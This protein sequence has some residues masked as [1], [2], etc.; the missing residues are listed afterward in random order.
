MIVIGVNM[1]YF[2][3]SSINT[4]ISN[5]EIRDKE[6]QKKLFLLFCYMNK[7]GLPV[8]IVKQAKRAIVAGR[9]EL[10]DVHLFPQNFKKSLR[11]ELEYFR[12]FPVLKEFHIFKYLRKDILAT[13]GKHL[14]KANFRRGKSNPTRSSTP[15]AR[16]RSTFTWCSR[17][18]SKCTTAAPTAFRAESTRPAPFLAKSSS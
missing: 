13:L 14:A 17:A 9:N 4:N 18:S 6:C 15:R 8:E 11:V 10:T 12:F 2:L 1:F 7:F 16:P 3:V 5:N